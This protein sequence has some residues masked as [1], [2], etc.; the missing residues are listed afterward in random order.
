MENA[1]R[2]V[3]T[4]LRKYGHTYQANLAM[5]AREQFMASPQAGCRV[6]N[7]D[8]WWGGSDSV[9][10]VDLAVDGGF[11]AQAREDA[12]R[13]WGALIEIYATMKAYGKSHPQAEIVTAQFNKWLT[14][15]V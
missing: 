2:T 1:L 14:S 10:A 5:I 15:H 12:K 8:E 11:G 13:L 4:L 3:E 6:L 9:A 7:D